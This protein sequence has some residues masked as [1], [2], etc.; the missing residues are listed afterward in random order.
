MMYKIYRSLT[1]ML[2]LVLVGSGCEG[3]PL[4]SPVVISDVP[5]DDLNISTQEN[6]MN[7]DIALSKNSESIA[8]VEQDISE[9][10]LKESASFSLLWPT[11][12]PEGF[13]FQRIGGFS[14]NGTGSIVGSDFVLNYGSGRDKWLSIRQRNCGQCSGIKTLHCI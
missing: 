9:A 11:Y 8:L 10:E 3:I 14:F 2:V 13:P 4:S 5:I 1:M 6:A 12:I 7:E